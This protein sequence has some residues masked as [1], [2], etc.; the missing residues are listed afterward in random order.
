MYVHQCY[1]NHIQCIITGLN[2]EIYEKMIRDSWVWKELYSV[3]NVRPSFNTKLGLYGG[4]MYTGLFYVLLRGKEPWTLSHGGIICFFSFPSFPCINFAQNKVFNL[5]SVI[6]PP[7]LFEGETWF[8]CLSFSQSVPNIC[9]HSSFHILNGN[10]SK[11]CIL[12]YYHI[13]ICIFITF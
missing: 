11:L 7:S 10:S 12:A 13:M 9:T 5:L 2:P 8:S 4:V 1:D 3:R 6:I